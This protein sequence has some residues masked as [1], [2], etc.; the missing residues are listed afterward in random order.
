MTEENIPV[1]EPT[2]IPVEED[3]KKLWC[4][5]KPKVGEGVAGEHLRDSHTVR[6]LEIDGV[7]L[8]REVCT[9]TKTYREETFK[10]IK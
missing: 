1:G 7:P 3:M 10:L 2:E 8:E 4:G 9:G 6:I 5:Y